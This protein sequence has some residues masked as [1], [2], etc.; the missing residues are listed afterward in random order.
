VLGRLIVSQA[1]ER[2]EG[3]HQGL[4]KGRAICRSVTHSFHLR[5]DLDA[6]EPMVP[7]VAMPLGEPQ[8]TRL[9]AQ[10]M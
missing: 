2:L 3:S 1:K 5:F 4:G 9:T 7:R 8:A 6:G 10:A